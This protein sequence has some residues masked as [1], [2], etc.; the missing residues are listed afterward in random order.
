MKKARK[1]K[2]K[3]FYHFVLTYRGAQDD[4]GRFAECMFNDL[5]FP[6]TATDFDEL[7][8]YIEM[9]ADPH[10]STYVFDEL[11]AIYA[12]KYGL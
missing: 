8:A 10:L 7:S 3:S 4:K 5:M 6:K 1:R 9:Q 12:T 2:M 11:W